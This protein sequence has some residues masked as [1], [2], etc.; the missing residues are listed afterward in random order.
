MDALATDAITKTFKRIMQAY[1]PLDMSRWHLHDLRHAHA[2]VL[3]EH[4]VHPKKIQA[5]LGHSS[6]QVTM[7][8]YGHLMEGQDDDIA[9][10]FE[11]YGKEPTVVTEAIAVLEAV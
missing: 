5:R 2:S 3:I 10:L 4:G 11:Q 6:I 9:E 7:D 1:K 8:R